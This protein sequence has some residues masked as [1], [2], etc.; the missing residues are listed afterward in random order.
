MVGANQGL[1]LKEKLLANSFG[2]WKLKSSFRM[3]FHSVC[4]SF[5]HHILRALS[6]NIPPRYFELLWVHYYLFC[7]S[8]SNIWT[9]FWCSSNVVS[10]P[11]GDICGRDFCHWAVSKRSQKPT[12]SSGGRQPAA[13]GAVSQGV[14][15]AE[16][17]KNSNNT[18]LSVF[19][20][21]HAPSILNNARNKNTPP[22]RNRCHSPPMTCY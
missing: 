4:G 18:T 19:F 8:V 15:S 22:C 7:I 16:N 20:C 13:S 12:K 10:A 2:L 17:W 14:P 5:M 3:T 21:Y 11:G 9:V 6:S 1:I